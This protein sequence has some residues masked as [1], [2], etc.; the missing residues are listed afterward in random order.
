MRPSS[1]RAPNPDFQDPR[2]YMGRGLTGPD[3]TPRPEVLGLRAVAMGRELLIRAVPLELVAA[4]VEAVRRLGAS[5]LPVDQ[6]R[7]RLLERSREP[8]L[9]R[10]PLLVRL[11]QAAASAI[12]SEA[13][14][15][16][17]VRHVARVLQLATFER[18]L[19]R[20]IDLEQ[21]AAQL[22]ARRAGSVRTHL[23]RRPPGRS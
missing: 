5:R 21:A 6:Q 8:H 13:D 9:Q 19:G 2:T 20:A 12:R 4:E 3:G 7:R 22:R 15:S 11:L 14:F 17:F 10:Y 16:A 1:P 18:V 23:R